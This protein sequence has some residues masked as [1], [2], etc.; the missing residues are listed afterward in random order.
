MHHQV[1]AV[2]VGHGAVKLAYRDSRGQLCKR[3]FRSI[4]V[5]H[6]DSAIAVSARRV[7]TGLS[8]M[9]VQ[10]D[11]TKF[12]VDL[13][14]T[15]IPATLLVERNETNDFPSR[16]EYRALLFA[17]LTAA[18]ADRVSVLVLGLPM[19]TFHRF[20]DVLQKAFQ[21]L[22]TFGVKPVYV[23]RVVVVPQPLGSLL[24][25][26]AQHSE[27][28]KTTTLCVVDFGHNTA[29]WLV[30]RDLK[31]EF[32]RSGGRPGGAVQVYRDIAES[33]S[34]DLVGDVFDGIDQIEFALRTGTPLL[35]HGQPV[36]LEQYLARAMERSVETARAIRVKVRS[37][38][39]LTLVLTGGG[40]PLFRQAIELVFPQ[41]RVIEM[42][43][44]RFTNVAGFLLYGE[45]LAR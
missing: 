9:T 43:E 2:D 3:S 44:A 23:E 39:D 41:N 14:E 1:L 5:P 22:L 21:G 30:G 24:T 27:L 8:V 36:G 31:T 10:V 33:I 12:D 45:Q 40:A 17:A 15:A 6:A 26:K 28:V 34:A 11:T 29:D 18:E 4:A 42:A 20:A 25:M 35:V 13:D 37:V 19:Y 16:R 32:G 38:G 7:Q